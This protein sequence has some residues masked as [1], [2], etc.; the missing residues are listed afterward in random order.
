MRYSGTKLG[1]N[2][3]NIKDL[4]KKFHQHDIV[5]FAKCPKP[6]CVE[7]STGET[8]TRLNEGVIDHTA[9][10]KRLHLY[11][12]SQESNHLVLC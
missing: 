7:D 4:V 12:Q 10:D 6:G 5:Y 1:T 3:T 9:R 11:K 2:F 8:Y